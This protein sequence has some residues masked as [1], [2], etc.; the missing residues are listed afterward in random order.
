MGSR[1]GRDRWESETRRARRTEGDVGRLGVQ[2]GRRR[3]PTR[4]V[5]CVENTGEVSAREQASGWLDHF[6]VFGIVEGRERVE[7]VLQGW[8]YLDFEESCLEWVASRVQT[9][10]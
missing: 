8:E 4:R 7:E 5:S 10:K 9:H 3:G 6:V 1:A 2:R